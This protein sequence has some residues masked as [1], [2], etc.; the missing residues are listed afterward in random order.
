MKRIASE[1][2][3]RVALSKGAMIEHSGNT[4]NAAR[5][6][7]E[8][9][10][11]PQAKPEVVVAAPPPAPAAPSAPPENESVNSLAAVV[12]SLVLEMKAQHAA[13]PKPIV[14]WVFDVQRNGTNTRITA[15]AIR[16]GDRT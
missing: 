12:E 16:E 10:R 11:R 15:T 4:I 7:M 5:G 6:R 9:V 8:L 13:E 2:L 1:D 3:H 14:E